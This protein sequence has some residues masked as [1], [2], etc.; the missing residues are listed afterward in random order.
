MRFKWELWLLSYLMVTGSN[1][2][3]VAPKRVA[4]LI[5][6]A[7]YASAPLFNPANDASDLAAALK[8]RGFDTLVALNSSRS[9][10]TTRIRAFVE[11]VEPGSVA[12][13]YYAG[14]GM[15]VRGKNYII[16]VDAHVQ[17]EADVLDQGVEIDSVLQRLEIK[18]AAINLVIL[19]ACRNNPFT[20]AYGGG[21]ASMDAPKGTLIAFA[22]SPGKLALDGKGRNGVFTKHLLA[23]I[24]LPGL[25]VEDVFKRVR[26]GVT[27]ESKGQQVPWENTSLTGDFYFV[28][29]ERQGAA[30]STASSLNA[31]QEQMRLAIASRNKPALQ[32]Y[33]ELS[34]TGEL[35]AVVASAFERVVAGEA[36]RAAAQASYLRDCNDC[37][38][39][40]PLDGTQAIGAFP[41]T[42]TEY[43][44]CRRANACE[45]RDVAEFGAENH[46]AI[47]VSWHDAQ[48][49]TQ[50]LSRRTGK[51][52]RLPTEDDWLRAVDSGR[53]VG[54]AKSRQEVPFVECRSGNGYDRSAAIVSAFPW[55]ES[56][57]ND[58]FPLT[59]PVGVFLPNAIGMYDWVGNVWQWTQTCSV[60]AQA[61]CEKFV[62]KGGS[63]ASPPS[64]L[65]P[66]ASL[67]AEPV[68]MGSTMGF[69][70]YRE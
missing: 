12:L 61:P 60:P 24:N 6:N 63:W 29:P 2:Q 5:G 22:T 21:L 35:R 3:G 8:S 58:G 65:T 46:P 38:Q 47:N 49:Y 69:R 55:K 36:T 59:S 66:A 42:V 53:Y 33:L 14:H 43:E 11:K 16:P 10:M 20:R 31:E 67:A 9:D 13:F 41:I 50:W 70:V 52:Y 25:K 19:D 27:E 1:A 30:A 15:Q 44:E 40:V 62:L 26:I 32:K 54:E 23:N 34:P 56:S 17:S 39:M 45:K 51:R 48:K 64:S 57:C 4:L 7:A 28:A 68:L 18:A 37:P